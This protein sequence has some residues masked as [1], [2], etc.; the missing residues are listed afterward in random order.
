MPI[1]STCSH[2]RCETLTIGP[3]CLE[4]EAPR[5]PLLTR[6]RP[7]VRHPRPAFTGSRVERASARADV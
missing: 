6:G 1:L 2:P 7:F 4:H 5:P 3:I